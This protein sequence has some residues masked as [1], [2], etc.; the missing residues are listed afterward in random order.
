[1]AT[2]DGVPVEFHIHAGGESEPVDL[3]A[4]SNL[5]TDAGYT[6]YVAEDLFN[7]ASGN[8]QQTARRQNSKRPHHPAQS[9]LIQY[10][11]KSI[12]TTFG[13]L[14]ARFSK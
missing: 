12:E 8:Q 2:S 5:Y 3:P 11:R 1:M 4:G 13:Q 7:E 6:D 9:S 10:F 14:T